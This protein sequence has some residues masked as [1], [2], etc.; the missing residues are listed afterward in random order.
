[1]N[2]T[3][4]LFLNFQEEMKWK[5]RIWILSRILG[6]GSLAIY[7]F[8]IFKAKYTD[9]PKFVGFSYFAAFTNLSHLMWIKYF[10]VPE[11][12]LKLLN[13]KDADIAYETIQKYHSI[14]VPPLLSG[15]HG[16]NRKPETS[17]FSKDEWIHYM[18]D[19]ERL[20]WKKYGKFY[21]YFYVFVFTC[22]LSFLLFG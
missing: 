6:F 20:D 18:N 1:M 17:L 13:P 15:I 12:F 10:E 3:D 4:T 19:L 22:F 5:K 16:I 14:V 11:L 7:T 21:I 2:E 8:M 9:S